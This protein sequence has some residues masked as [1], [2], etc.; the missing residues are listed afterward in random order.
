MKVLQRILN[1]GISGDLTSLQR[2]ARQ[3]FN[4]DLIMG[5]V[6]PMITVI[7]YEIYDL[8]TPVFLAGHIFIIAFFGSCFYFVSKG[9][10]E[11][12][13][14]KCIGF[15]YIM[16]L[17]IVL[18]YQS[19][20]NS[21]FF[22]P[23]A[24]NAL[25]Y[26][27]ERKRTSISILLLFLVTG[28]VLFLMEMNH[29]S[30]QQNTR[31]QILNMRAAL[32]FFTYLFAY[33]IVSFLLM[34][35]RTITTK[36]VS[37]EGVK[38][39]LKLTTE[40][41][42]HISFSPPISLELSI[43]EQYVRFRRDGYFLQCNDAF[44]R[45]YGYPEGKVLNG[46]PVT[47]FVEGIPDAG[48][49]VTFPDFAAANYILL[50]KASREWNGSGE[51]VH[52]LNNVFGIIEKNQLKGIWGTQRDISE[53]KA[54]QDTIATRDEITEKLMAN[55]P[56]VYYRF[57]EDLNFTLSV[58]GALERLKLKPNE[59]VG[60]SMKD[61]YK[62]VPD[63]IAAHQAAIDGKENAFLSKVPNQEE[64][65]FFDSR[66]TF[67][68][69]KKEGI[70]FALETTERKIA[71]NA[72]L[73]SENRYRNLF[74]STFDA[75]FIFNIESGLVE[76]CNENAKIMFELPEDIDIQ[77]LSPI[78]LTPQYQPDGELSS[79]VIDS[80]IKDLA[81]KK[82]LQFEFFHKRFGGEVFETETT[83]IPSSFNSK[84]ILVI[85][86]DVSKKRRA[87]RALRT[88][89]RQLREAQKVALLGSWEYDYSS[90]GFSC[91]EQLHQMF[92]MHKLSQA[93]YEAC[94]QVL[95]A[96]E[97]Q[98][99][100][101]EVKEVAERSAFNFTYQKKLA[102]GETKWFQMTGEKSFDE[103]GQPAR[104]SGIVQDITTQQH[105]EEII[106]KALKALN[107][108]NEDLKKYIDSNMQLENFAYMASHDLK[109]PIRTIV[110][111]T[112]LLKRSL[113]DR[114]QE[115]EQEYL[116]YIST[117]ANSMKNLIEDLLTYS[118]VNTNNHQLEE[119][120]L[121]RILESIRADL[122]TAL[123][124]SEA[125]IK[126]KNIPD[127]IQAD[128][129]MMRQ[130]FQN[131]LENAIKFRRPGVAPKIEIGCTSTEDHWNFYIRD[132][133]IGISPE[134]QEKIFLLFRKLHSSSQY[135]GTGI[136]LALCKKIVEQHGGKIWV[137]DQYEGGTCFQFTL[138]KQLVLDLVSA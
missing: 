29:F 101:N 113:N 33:K 12:C 34:Y 60:K 15:I 118:R 30:F 52:L 92:E 76:E 88:R 56:V 18:S 106:R 70:G 13:V 59:V 40:G 68:A 6:L 95:V 65:L 94:I 44:A 24:L 54:T 43:E 11:Y 58:G 75:I 64:E 136:G 19:L 16:M 28:L 96:E 112:Q 119:V 81:F 98:K 123:E 71:E 74:N 47:K 49:A 45:L 114:L 51:Y 97:Y 135:E 132:N 72:L 138:R 78:Y 115:N 8:T 20:F 77:A 83:L 121:P 7:Y 133:G 109:A 62:H 90:Q 53:L 79:A 125:N 107:E 35:W 14:W 91:S 48:M 137:D 128:S 55:F 46:M 50:N 21:I 42:Y 82:R 22:I 25:I 100:M 110:S 3:I 105:Q 131:L 37:E 84:E 129:T 61:I 36:E 31:F 73:K 80:Q 10:Y 39:F 9:Y 69:K 1:N 38:Q 111:F 26:F 116:Q 5:M 104:I 27:P 103:E 134:F 23:L 85:I 127:S 41:I 102:T 122:Q 86:N 57:D 124:D 108:K 63:I 130:L 17:T 117:G 66:V 2:L 4:F 87:E 93:S 126:V 89:E 120:L 99:L 67:D 32:A